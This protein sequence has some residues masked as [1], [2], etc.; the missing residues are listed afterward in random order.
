MRF[1]ADH[2]NRHLIPAF[3]R[4][5]QAQETDKQVEGAKEF[6]EAIEKLVDLFQ[7]AEKD[8]PE[9]VGLWRSDGKLS[10]ADVM[11]VPWLFR[12]TNVLV[13]YR[14]FQLPTGDRFT[15]YMDRL[16]KHESVKNTCSNEDLYLDS[17][18]RYA[19]NRPNTSQVANA[20]NSGRAL[21]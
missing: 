13:H 3:Y 12:A 7:K 14:G 16:L 18:A 21:P 5:L 20:T 19:E 8:A 17:Y 9:A 4:Y 10:W 11:A 2:I 6:L 15:A 1:H